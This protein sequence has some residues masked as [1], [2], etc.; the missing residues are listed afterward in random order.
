MTRS[1]NIA[2]YYRLIIYSNIKDVLFGRKAVARETMTLASELKSHLVDKL[3]DWQLMAKLKAV[4]KWVGLGQVQSFMSTLGRVG[5]L[6]LCVGLGRVKK[7]GLTSKSVFSFLA[8]WRRASPNA[9]TYSLFTRQNK[10]LRRR[11]K[12]CL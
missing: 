5:S 1:C 11:L 7:I 4:R 9:R 12:A 8:S 10:S 2:I 3:K 6:H